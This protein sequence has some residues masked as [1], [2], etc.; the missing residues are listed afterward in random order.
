MWS[1]TMWSYLVLEITCSR[2][3]LAF[4]Q[5]TSSI[6]FIAKPKYADARETYFYTE[7]R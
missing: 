2:A 1:S 3:H 7:Q 5:G 4:S 6:A